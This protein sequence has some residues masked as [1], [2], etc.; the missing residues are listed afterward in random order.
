MNKKVNLGMK[1]FSTVHFKIAKWLT[2]HSSGLDKEIT[3]TTI[4]QTTANVELTKKRRRLYRNSFSGSVCF[5]KWAVIG[6]NIR[7]VPE[8][9]LR[10]NVKKLTNRKKL[11]GTYVSRRSKKHT[12]IANWPIPYGRVG[13]QKIE[14]V[15]TIPFQGLVTACL[16]KWIACQ[17]FHSSHL[18]GAKPLTGLAAINLSR[19]RLLIKAR[20]QVV[21]VWV[22]SENSMDQYYDIEATSKRRVKRIWLH[23]SSTVAQNQKSTLLLRAKWQR[24]C[25]LPIFLG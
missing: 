18:Y 25:S 12:K 16:S 2:E 13:W 20:T 5:S 22:P 19:T 4:Y 8:S 6:W 17:K 11:N 1:K 21:P 15:H 7:I 9:P 3:G 10:C 14:G 24:K 23:F